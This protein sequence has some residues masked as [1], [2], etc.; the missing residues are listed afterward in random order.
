M[1]KKFIFISILA[2]SLF[3]HFSK[4]VAAFTPGSN[5]CEPI[6]YDGGKCYGVCFYETYKKFCDPEGCDGW[7]PEYDGVYKGQT[8]DC[9][10]IG[11][12]NI[13]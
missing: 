1:F 3:F 13:C 5:D 2:L 9:D 11:V 12:G 4:P 8:C 7:P 10:Y 6:S